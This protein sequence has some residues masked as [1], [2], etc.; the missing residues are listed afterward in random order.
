M[1][2]SVSAWIYGREPLEKKLARLQRFGY[3]GVELTVMEPAKMETERIKRLVSDHDL[4]ISN[5]S[6]DWSWDLRKRDLCN[7]DKK[8]R[9]ETMAY[10]KGCIELAKE[11]GA[12]SFGLIPS[13]T[14]KPGPLTSSEDEWKWAVEAVAE[15]AEYAEQLGVLLALEPANRYEVYM[16]NTVDDALKFARDVGSPSVRVLLDCFHMNIEEPGLPLA[17][18]KAGNLLANVHIADSNRQAVG[19]GHT[20]FK[21]IIR[22]VKEIDY[23]YYLTMELVPEGADPTS[24]FRGF[25]VDE[26]VLDADAQLCIT[27]LKLYETLV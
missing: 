11:L 2:Y 25:T 20:D 9:Q 23:P 17:F 1:K 10:V 18:R 26:G 16:L 6:G 27:S 19:K 24:V 22:T 7:P 5:L 21:S 14:G 12:I 3:D 8:V 15:L 13:A 4:V